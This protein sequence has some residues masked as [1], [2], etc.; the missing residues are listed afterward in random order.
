MSY[1]IYVKTQSGDDY[2]WSVDENKLKEDYF[3]TFLK[4]KMDEEFG[5]IGS[6]LIKNSDG[7]KIETPNIYKEIDKALDK[8]YDEEE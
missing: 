6:L 2:L 7:K 8:Y 5:F 3:L 1:A 4:A